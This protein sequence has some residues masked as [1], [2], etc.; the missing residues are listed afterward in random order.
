MDGNGMEG[1]LFVGGRFRVLTT[2]VPYTYAWWRHPM[3]W[4]LWHFSENSVLVALFCYLIL[5]H[6]NLQILFQ[7]MACW[8]LIIF[9]VIMNKINSLCYGYS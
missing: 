7:V 8:C 4:K 6:L 9:W 2:V 5:K 3:C 1:I